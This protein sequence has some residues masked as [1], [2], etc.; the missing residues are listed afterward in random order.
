MSEKNMKTKAVLI[1]GSNSGCGKT[2]VALGLMAAFRKIGLNVQGFKV[3]PDYID[4]SLHRIITGKP[5]INLDTWMMPDSFLRY[6]FTS[7]ASQ[8]DIS[9]IEGVM[10]I[11]DGKKPDSGEGST[12]ELAEKLGIPVILVINA[13]SMARTAAAI[14]KGLIDFNPKLNIIGVVLNNI[15]SDNHLSLLKKSIQTYCGLPVLGGIKKNTDFN[16]PSRHL[17]LFMGDEGVLPPKTISHLAETIR[18]NI[19]LD[20]ILSFSKISLREPSQPLLNPVQ[21]QKRLGIARDQAFCFYYEDNLEILKQLGYELVEFSPVSDAKLP[22][23]EAF[24]FGGGYPEL[25]AESL[26]NNTSMRESV[27]KRSHEGGVIYAECGGL[28][29]LGQSITTIDGKEYAMS[30]CM[31]YRTQMLPSLQS[32][33]YVEIYPEEDY[34]ILKRGKKMRGHVFHYSDIIFDAIK[35]LSFYSG[36]PE[37]K[38]ISYKVRNTLASYVHLHFSLF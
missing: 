9:I 25:H 33:G 32:L 26:S 17:G 24:Y 22:D 13:A 37:G 1:A 31:N 10:G 28:M 16:I 2:T 29:Y 15:G 18:T 19:D 12:A 14:V 38:G 20:K 21:T 30:G 27:R 35:P 7:R 3:G 4:P 6:S 34:F 5:S 36:N 11:Y 8:A 23:A